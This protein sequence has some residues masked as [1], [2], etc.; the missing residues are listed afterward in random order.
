MWPGF[1]GSEHVTPFE[2]DACAGARDD[3]TAAQLASQ[4]EIPVIAEVA[5]AGP[6]DLAGPVLIDGRSANVSGCRESGCSNFR[7]ATRGGTL[8]GLNVDPATFAKTSDAGELVG[9][10]LA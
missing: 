1:P 3:V 10:T 9:G 7:H 5:I 4:D 8:T 2:H 6:R